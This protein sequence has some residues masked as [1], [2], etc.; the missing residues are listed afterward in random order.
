[1]DAAT[2][3]VNNIRCAFYRRGPVWRC[4]R[5][6]RLAWEHHLFAVDP[7]VTE[8]IVQLGVVAWPLPTRG[9]MAW[10]LELIDHWQ[11]TDTIDAERADELR[12]DVE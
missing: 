12:L 5:C 9:L 3:P 6:D 7:A 2:E 1:M 4:T 11:A 8:D 10:P